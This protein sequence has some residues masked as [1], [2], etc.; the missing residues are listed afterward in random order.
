MEFR[1]SNWTVMAHDISQSE[2]DSRPEQSLREEVASI[3]DRLARLPI[4]DTRSAE[5][6][7]GYDESGFPT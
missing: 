4:L 3:Q 1:P 5:E 6:I 2:A 7:L